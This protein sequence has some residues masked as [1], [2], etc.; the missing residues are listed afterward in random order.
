[1]IKLLDRSPWLVHVSSMS[2][3]DQIRALEASLARMTAEHVRLS[4]E[5]TLAKA[6]KA[7]QAATTAAA[8]ERASRKR[9][10][11]LVEQPTDPTARAILA[12]GRKARGEI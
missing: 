8:I 3:D 4:W 1:V 11:E 9:R 5:L 2:T 7:Q 12:A 6:A 10:G